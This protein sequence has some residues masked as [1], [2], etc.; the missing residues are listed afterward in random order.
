M[1]GWALWSCDVIVTDVLT[2]LSWAKVENKGPGEGGVVGAGNR[3]D[4]INCQWDI[5]MDKISLP[6]ATD[7]TK[8]SSN[9]LEN[10]A[11]RF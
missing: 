8:E 5:Y 6:K 7:P 4:G 1:F 10:M 9:K 3:D 2:C 11:Y